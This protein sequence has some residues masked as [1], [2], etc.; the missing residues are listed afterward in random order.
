MRFLVIGV[1]VGSLV[2]F[3]GASGAFAQQK[4]GAQKQKSGQCTYEQC[5]DIAKKRGDSSSLANHYCTQNKARV[6]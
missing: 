5:M 4:Q 3:S 1:V 6:C 2:A